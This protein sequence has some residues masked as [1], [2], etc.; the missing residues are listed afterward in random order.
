MRRRI[1]LFEVSIW[2][3]VV[4]ESGTLGVGKK[5][6]EPLAHSKHTHDIDLQQ[7]PGDRKVCVKCWSG[8]GSAAV[9]DQDVKLASRRFR[10]F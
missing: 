10:D 6:L 1:H 5:M 9:V 2:S 7:I 3:A 8:E 4:H